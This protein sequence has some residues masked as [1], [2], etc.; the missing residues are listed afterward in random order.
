MNEN[1]QSEPFIIKKVPYEQAFKIHLGWLKL[2]KP[3]LHHSYKLIKD[4][5]RYQIL[6]DIF[7]EELGI[8]NVAEKYGLKYTSVKNIIELYKK[9]GRIYKKKIR[10][11]TSILESN[12]GIKNKEVKTNSSVHLKEDVNVIK[13]NKEKTINEKAN[14]FEIA[15]RD[16]GIL[17]N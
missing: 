13:K 3:I 8:R 17:N 2:T 14:E 1:L 11:R 10:S 4:E 12:L 6:K 16:L 15:Q 5:V 9:E 7:D